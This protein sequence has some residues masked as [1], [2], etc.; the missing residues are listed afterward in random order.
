M[1]GRVA[2]VTGA[3]RG[4]GR[5]TAIRLARDFGGVALVARTRDALTETAEAVRAA[6]AE[7]LVFAR[8]LRQ[9]D[10]AAA[11]VAATRDAFGRIDAVACIAG[12]VAQVDLFAL[13]DE[14]WDDGLALKFHSARRLTIAAWNA[15]RSSHG[16][17]AITSGTSAYTPKASL[18]AVGTINAAI[19]ALAKAF[20]DR[21]VRD[22][23]QVNTILPGSVVTDRRRTMLQGYA[24]AHGLSL[25]AAVDQFAA[26]VGIARYG[27]PDDIANAVAF[28]FTPD[29]HWI[30]G[31]A[32]RV[33]GGETKLL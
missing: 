15:L 8:D 5:A 11:I 1:T 7:P 31:T 27:R 13:T 19:L 32:I 12:A 9:R 30:T 14:Q 28:L 3:S 20:A 10:A 6:G 17:V 23:V 22:G 33:D 21:G 4:I 2:V 18:A 16:S 29:S 24:D 26:E 25:A